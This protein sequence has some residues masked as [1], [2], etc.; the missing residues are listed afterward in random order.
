MN[1][2]GAESD[3]PGEECGIC[4]IYGAPDA[5]VLIGQ[6]LFSMQHRGQEGAGISV[7]D[8]SRIHSHKGLGLVS[9]VFKRDS[10]WDVLKGDIGIG[11]VRYSTT[12]STRVTNVQP[13]VVE[14]ADGIWGIAHNG[15]LTNARELRHQYQEGGSIF[16][17]STDSEILLHLLADPAHRSS[18]NRV[19]SA[20]QK[21]RGAFSFLI[22]TRNCLM[23]ARDPLG[24]RPLSIG[25][26]GDA[27]VLASETCALAQIGATFERDVEPGELV[28]IDENGLHSRSFVESPPER[29]ASCIFE[30]VY[31]A[32]PDS[33][34]FGECVHEVRTKLGKRLA[35]EH[36]VDADIVVPIPDSGNSAALGYANEAG[37]PLNYGFVRNHYVGRTFIM[38][39]QTSRSS[40][41]DMKLSV[42]RSVVNGKRVIVIDDSIIRGTTA[43]R[44]IQALRDQGATEVH[45]R[46][47][48]PPTMHPCFFGID[49]PTSD[50][51]IASNKTH[52]EIAEWLGC[53]TLGYLS[54]DG[55]LASVD[56]PDDF[57]T[58]CFSGDYPMPIDLT[59][60]KESLESPSDLLNFD[61]APE[62]TTTQ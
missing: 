29:L 19:A 52:D 20:L 10:V 2:F 51:L 35:V 23:G 24:F 37:L 45:M 28:I 4:G 41:N 17:T 9:Q 39:E 47:S 38:P 5:A 58:A 49:F 44:R 8:G 1:H 42:A 26:L 7:S 22:M 40:S 57:C 61:E 53:D 30:H 12:G 27:Y 18:P 48:C 60:T 11:H 25:R 36:P 3:H 56:K 43:K 16:Q 31:F 13:L 21:L 14:L 50:E 32:R 33:I 34:L 55:L 59:Q 62:S 46:I 54:I 15:N 6:G